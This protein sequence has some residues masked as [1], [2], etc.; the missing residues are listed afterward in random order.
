[1]KMHSSAK[2]KLRLIFGTV[3]GLTLAAVMPGAA[4]AADVQMPPPSTFSVSVEGGLSNWDPLN[5]WWA[6][7]DEAIAGV[8]CDPTVADSCETQGKDP[9]YIKGWSG[10][11]EFDWRPQGM[12]LD[13]LVRGRYDVS[14]TTHIAETWRNNGIYILPDGGTADYNEN[15][16]GLDFEVGHDLGLGSMNARVFGGV[17]FARFKGNSSFATYQ[18]ESD[19]SGDG[20][21]KA[22]QN[23]V[24]NIDRTFTGIGPRIGLNATLPFGDGGF[25]IDFAGSGALLLGDRVT[26]V[27]YSTYELQGVKPEGSTQFVVVPNLEASAALFFKPTS[28]SKFSVGYRYDRYFGVMDTGLPGVEDGPNKQDRTIQGPFAKIMF[29]F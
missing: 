9:L 2:N 1:M 23:A 28:N 18:Y 10:A 26:T 29:D 14:N 3:S 22:G 27:S 16:V 17:R 5:L 8:V 20:G 11:A 6:T 15:H 25:G 24:G 21:E 12:G 13:F 19:W 7:Q 4:D